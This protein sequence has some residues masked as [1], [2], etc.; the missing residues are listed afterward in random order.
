M[1]NINLIV[2]SFEQI[3]KKNADSII[4]FQKGQIKRITA[5]LLK[6]IRTSDYELAKTLPNIL[7]F[8]ILKTSIYEKNTH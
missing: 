4:L 2:L 7:Y 5:I 1:S 3:Y 8:C 6:K